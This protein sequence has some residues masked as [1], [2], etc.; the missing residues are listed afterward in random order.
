MIASPKSVSVE[1]SVV[2]LALCT[3]QTNAWTTSRTFWLRIPHIL[4]VWV[5]IICRNFHKASKADK[6]RNKK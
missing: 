3:M 4:V 2:M 1:H 6:N 5:L